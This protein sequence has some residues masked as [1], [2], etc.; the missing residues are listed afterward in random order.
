MGESGRVSGTFISWVIEEWPVAAT[1]LLAATLLAILRL[2]GD[3][4]RLRLLAEQSS[5]GQRAEAETT[6]AHLIATERAL[7]ARV[8]QARVE[9]QDALGRLT[10]G[11]ARDQGEARTMME[12]KLREM[13]E[14]NAA[15]LAAIEH[16][17][18][19]QL[20]AAVERQMTTSFQRVL[21]QFAAVQKAMVDV[22]TVSAGIG[23]LKRIF[24]NVKTRGGWG[25]TQLRALLDDLLPPG[26]YE[27]N[28]ALGDG[29]VVEFAVRMPGRGEQR[30]L[31]P[32]DAKFPLADYE[33]LLT[34]AEDGDADAERGARRALE[35]TLRIEARRIASKY[36]VPP[37][38]T[39]F[40]V[41]YLP[42]DGL[43]AEI[44]RMP[45]LV[46]DL[47]RTLRILVMG[48]GLL[49]GLLRT[50]HLGYVTLAL[51]QK[52]EQIGRLLGATRQEMVR[53]DEVLERLARNAG[54]MART[55]EDARTRT[56]V[57]QR[58][59]R[60]VETVDGPEA[61]ALLPPTG[62]REN[63]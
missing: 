37:L 61:D 29:R 57:V 47:G 54:S 26:G 14:T 56:R 25:E 40:A 4:Q 12:A 50:V 32:I 2:G 59:L 28:A 27:A 19:A 1:V 11:S 24:S 44:A 58:K 20:H 35:A 45:G 18:G 36:I 34:A 51:E 7:T 52:A 6:R 43:Y 21:D 8:E 42:T 10:A 62:E 41:L 17:V 30:A 22:Q 63:A 5:A 60:E 16:T 55:I 39:E 13:A 33:R 15:R 23:D 9:Q 31:L 3:I 48:P 53:M 38:T 46:D 49:P